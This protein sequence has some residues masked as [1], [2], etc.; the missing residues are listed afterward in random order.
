MAR[1]ATEEASTRTQ[2]KSADVDIGGPITKGK[3]GGEEAEEQSDEPIAVAEK[4]CKER[5]TVAAR[6]RQRRR[7]V[8]LAAVQNIL[9]SELRERREERAKV[10]RLAVR[11]ALDVL[12]E[13]ERVVRRGEPVRAPRVAVATVK[14]TEG[15]AVKK[16]NGRT[17]TTE[18]TVKTRDTEEGI[19]DAEWLAV[20]AALRGDVSE[21]A[22]RGRTLVEMR[23]ARKR[24]IRERDR[25]VHRL[26]NKYREQYMAWSRHSGSS[27]ASGVSFIRPELLLEPSKPWYPIE[28]LSFAPRTSDWLSEVPALDARQPWRTGWMNAPH[29]HPY[30]TT[31][32]PCQRNPELFNPRG[33]RFVNVYRSVV[34]DPSLDST[35]LIPTWRSLF[36]SPPGTPRPA[37]AAAPVEAG[38]EDSQGP[39][40]APAAEAQV[41]D[42]EEKESGDSASLTLLATAARHLE[43]I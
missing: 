11:Q 14:K 3:S 18:K 13:A 26:R 37:L 30:N 24:A 8:N 39:A 7:E 2:G 25:R 27:S 23:A 16:K 10:L 35:E 42:E 15:R 38:T 6:R 1:V 33:T 4:E 22:A 19:A 32:C 43:S 29:Q 17:E 40:S 20:C 34:V 9:T 21:G 41:L 12:P 28:N 36:D 31:Y 5:R